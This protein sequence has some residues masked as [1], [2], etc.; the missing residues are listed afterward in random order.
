MN[1]DLL[2]RLARCCAH[3]TRQAELVNEL[4]AG[5]VRVALVRVPGQQHPISH[6]GEAQLA[7]SSWK[8]LRGRLAR[9]GFY[10]TYSD[11]R[12]HIEMRFSR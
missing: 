11:S 2:D 9:N 7:G 8:N 5:P 4:L 1:Q 10:F 3:G 12:L 6:Y